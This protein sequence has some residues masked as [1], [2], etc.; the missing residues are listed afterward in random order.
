MK[1]GNNPVHILTP[2]FKTGFKTM[3]EQKQ[4]ALNLFNEIFGEII[5][6]KDRII[7]I[8]NE[9]LTDLA[10]SLGYDLSQFSRLINPPIGK[11]PNSASLSRLIARLQLIAENQRLQKELIDS[12]NQCLFLKKQRKLALLPF[13]ILTVIILAIFFV[14]P[15]IT[16]PSENQQAVQEQPYKMIVPDF[17][18][19]ERLLESKGKE[20]AQGLAQNAWNIVQ[21]HYE[22]LNNEKPVSFESKVELMSTIQSFIKNGL[23]ESRIRFSKKNYVISHDYK[24]IMDILDHILP[25]NTCFQCAAAD[26]LADTLPKCANVYDKKLW[27]LKST[28]LGDKSISQAEFMTKIYQGVRE[29]QFQIR[30]EEKKQFEHF[31]L[32]GS[33][34]PVSE[35]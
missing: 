25:V 10:E 3:N 29:A 14:R 15:Q 35:W 12:K 23:A 32:T 22:K 9:S 4:Q 33:F 21:P 24:G 34:Q 17:Y 8:G 11:E 19:Y 16:T 1:Q 7:Q 5:Y 20:V 18:H 2:P 6:D 13:F 30:K 31:L 26:I 28:L 27:E